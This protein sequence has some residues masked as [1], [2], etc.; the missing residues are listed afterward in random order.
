M[1][2]PI[3]K[4]AVEKHFLDLFGFADKDAAAAGDASVRIKFIGNDEDVEE[5]KSRDDT[6]KAHL[7]IAYE[8][9]TEEGAAL[10]EAGFAARREDSMFYVE[11]LTSAGKG[12]TLADQIWASVKASLR[13]PFLTI[14]VDSKTYAVR[15]SQ[16]FTES[17]RGARFGGRWAGTALAMQYQFEFES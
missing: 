7:F 1:T 9:S 3:V 5:P 6:A 2:H 17:D 16:D 10:G 14:A 12:E 13:R 11:V 15:L 4:A 8:L